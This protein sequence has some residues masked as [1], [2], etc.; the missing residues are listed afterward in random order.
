MRPKTSSGMLSR[1]DVSKPA[2]PSIAAAA[3]EAFPVIRKLY[4]LA[5]QEGMEAEKKHPTLPVPDPSDERQQQW[6]KFLSELDSIFHDHQEGMRQVL[7]RHDLFSFD[8]LTEKLEGLQRKAGLIPDWKEKGIQP[9]GTPEEHFLLSYMFYAG[10]VFP[11][12]QEIHLEFLQQA[13][14]EDLVPALLVLGDLYEKGGRD[15]EG[16]I[17]FAQ[18]TTKAMKMYRRAANKGPGPGHS[19]GAFRLG[20][21][22]LDGQV[23]DRDVTPGGSKADEIQEKGLELIRLAADRGH[24]QALC[25]LGQFYYSKKMWRQAAEYWHK[26][27]WL[28]R[29]S[30]AKY[31]LYKMYKN[32]TKG[33]P[34]DIARS[35]QFLP[36]RQRPIQFQEEKNEKD[37][38]EEQEAEEVDEDDERSGKA[39]TDKGIRWVISYVSV[40]VLGTISGLLLNVLVHQW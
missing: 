2:S 25:K 26:A 11:P 21:M 29:S 14:K 9:G 37:G 34:L 28:R 23:K 13:A 36:R 7:I 35:E 8:R 10:V 5:N 38:Q 16:R 24:R 3:R 31:R 40:A 27:V 4:A 1:G 33:L 15:A 32:G 30:D 19:T 6:V 17:T 20:L 22:Y 18:D 12:D 39:A